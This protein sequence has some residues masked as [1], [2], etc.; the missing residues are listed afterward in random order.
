MTTGQI[1]A[2]DPMASPGGANNE[3]AHNAWLEIVYD[4]LD[5]IDKK[6][7]EFTLGLHGR[8]QLGNA[9]IAARLKRTPGAISQRKAKIQQKIR[10]EEFLSPFI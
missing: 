3:K 5:S 6:I 9:E 7:M 10:Q 4:D 1:S 2:I 8:P